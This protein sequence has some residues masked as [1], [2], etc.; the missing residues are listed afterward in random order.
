MCPTTLKCDLHDRAI[1]LG[2]ADMRVTTPD[3]IPGFADGLR[4]FLDAGHAGDMNWLAD[5][6]SQRAN[7]KALWPDSRSVITLSMSY[8]PDHDPMDSLAAA[9]RANI[10]VYA[11]GRDYHDVIKK[12]LK[13][14]ARWLVDET[15]CELKVFVDT[16]PVPEKAL[17]AAAGL[18]WQGKHTNL[19][20]RDLGSWFFLGAIY[21]TLDLAQ[22]TS[23]TDHC[24]TCTACQDI[25]PTDA[26]PEPYKI[27]ARRCI[28]YLTIEHRG[29]IAEEF[30][31]PM[32]NRIYGCDD[33]LAVCP[34]NK[35]AA[36]PGDLRLT[37]KPENDLPPLADLLILNDSEFRARFSGSPIKRTGR[38][39]FIR[40]CL[41]AAGNSGDASLV[42]LIETL[43]PDPS[44]LVRAMAVWALSRLCEATEFAQRRARHAKTEQ[45][46]D[47]LNEWN[48]TTR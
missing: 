33:C 38:D 22:D 27:D 14:L 3:A 6:A 2:F 13:I 31:I 4:E 26:F 41:I 8:A 30:R 40:N 21:T 17:A 34:W 28:S 15:G 43:L 23:E 24:G 47:V 36:P 9:D 32:G 44:P 16:A 12:K 18:G 46:Q 35:Y 29:H 45:D 1:E 5:R 25:C 10:S 42:P 19:V 20:S 39:R 48:R 37:A 7:P 11:R